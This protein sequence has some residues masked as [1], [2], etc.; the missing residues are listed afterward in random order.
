MDE[1]LGN[2]SRFDRRKFLITTSI[3][4]RRVIFGLDGIFLR[5]FFVVGSGAQR[6]IMGCNNHLNESK[7]L[8]FHITQN[9][10]TIQQKSTKISRKGSKR[11]RNLYGAQ[12][13]KGGLNTR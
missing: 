3:I 4:A 12:R 11:R 5:C 8:K 2:V 9:T 13:E 7:R 1:F 6:K 10:S